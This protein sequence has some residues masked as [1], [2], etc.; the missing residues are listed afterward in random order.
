MRFY[1]GTQFPA[2]YRGNVFIAEHGSWNRS[3]KSGYRVA[4]VAID[5]QGRAGAPETFVQGWLQVDGTGN[6]SV[7]G[8]P[9]DVLAAARRIAADQ[10]RHGR[11]DLS[12]P[13]QRAVRI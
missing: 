9:A 11:R 7:W 6:E 12:H 13:L 5:A 2:A 1:T 4:R 10:R 8:R 3:R